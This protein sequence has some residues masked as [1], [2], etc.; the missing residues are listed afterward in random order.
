MPSTGLSKTLAI[1]EVSISMISWPSDSLSPS[2]ADHLASVPCCMASP[3]LGMTM[4]WMSG[5]DGFLINVALTAP[6]PLLREG[7]P[8]EAEAGV[9]TGAPPSARRHP[10]ENGTG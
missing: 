7:P 2:A 5:M 4:G 10:P 8:S 1:F 9:G 6:P 3:H